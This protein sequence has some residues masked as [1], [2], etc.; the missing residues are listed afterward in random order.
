MVG[1]LLDCSAKARAQGVAVAVAGF[2]DVPP[3]VAAEEESA[4]GNWLVTRGV[5]RSR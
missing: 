2:S 4:G 1:W 3:E 5:R